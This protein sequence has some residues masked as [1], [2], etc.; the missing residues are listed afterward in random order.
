MGHIDADILTVSNLCV[1]HALPRRGLRRR[2]AQAVSNVSFHLPRG[3]TLGLVGPSGSGKSSLARAILRLSP[4]AR[5]TGSVCFDGQD[6]F[7]ASAGRLRH[8]RRR[9]QV[10][11]QD[12]LGQLDPRMTVGRIIAEPLNIHRIVP[13][14]HQGRRV[15][16]LLARVHLSSDAVGRLPHELSGGQRQRVAIARAL[17]CEPELIVLDEPVSGLDVSVQ[18]HILNLLKDLQQQSHLSMIFIGHDLPVVSHMADEI[19]RLRDGMTD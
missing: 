17:A 7:A 10:V 15:D 4:Q 19:L 11:F 6:L 3:R 2:F 12:P 18:A 14:R 1:R 13:R 8:L 9:M 16:E 5:V